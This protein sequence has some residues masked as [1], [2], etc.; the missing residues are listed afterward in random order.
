MKIKGLEFQAKTPDFLLKL[1]DETKGSTHKIDQEV[2]DVELD[3]ELPLVVELDDAPQTI[4]EPTKN[5][6]KKKQVVKVSK[7]ERR[8]LSNKKLLSFDQ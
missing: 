2:A 4:A 8:K 7:K 3:D 1:K 6:I 5:E